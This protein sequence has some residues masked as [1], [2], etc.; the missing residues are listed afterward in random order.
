MPYSHAAAR[1]SP[2]LLRGFKVAGALELE[3][4]VAPAGPAAVQLPCK[5]LQWVAQSKRCDEKGAGMSW[6]PVGMRERLCSSRANVC[7]RAVSG[8]DSQSGGT[9]RGLASAGCKHQREAV[10][11][12]SQACGDNKQ[13]PL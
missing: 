1:A 13:Q 9:G 4:F 2:S 8:L 5:H 7:S 11:S 10:Q 12:G 3:R 6:L